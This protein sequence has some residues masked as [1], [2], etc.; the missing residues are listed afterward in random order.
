[1]SGIYVHVPFCRTACH[2]CDFHFSTSLLKIDSYVEALLKDVE[3]RC[4]NPDWG[5]L[6]FQTLYFGGGTPSVLS[7]DAL[8]AIVAKISES[9]KTNVF[10][11]T[12]IE[13][14]PEDVTRQALEGWRIAGFNRLSIGVQS[15]CDAQLKWMN[16][17]HSGKEALAAVA[18]AKDAGFERIS[19]DLIYGL[20]QFDMAWEQTVDIALGLPID[21]IS[22]YALTVE[23]K[24]VLG[25]RVAKGLETEMPD[26]R[27]EKDYRYICDAA[28]SKG[29]DHYEVSNWA[30]GKSGRAIHNTGYWSGDPYLGLGAGSHGFVGGKRYAVVSN[31]P[32]Y[33]AALNA[34]K[35]PLTEEV[36]SNRDRCNESLMTGLRTASGVNFEDLEKRWGHN[37][38]K[39]NQALF[40]KWVLEGGL[41]QDSQNPGSVFRIPEAKWLI[42]DRIASDLFVT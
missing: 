36:L 2:Y 17:K 19:I 27:V 9:F 13:V 30:R 24:T 12:T 31:N 5:G 35:L 26:E 3:L 29:F 20:P 25:S 7:S 1:M 22:C 28:N 8:K 32:K 10:L 4:K 16:R 34:D 38:A 6:E 14:N 18:L 40:N 21:H 23:P 15:F 41:V 33:I 39:H 42:G 11:E 37:P